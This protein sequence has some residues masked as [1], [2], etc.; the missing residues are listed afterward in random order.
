M[1]S[2]AVKR[3]REVGKFAVVIKHVNIKVMEV[4]GRLSKGSQRRARKLCHECK[5]TFF[6]AARLA[7]W[8][9]YSLG[10]TFQVKLCLFVWC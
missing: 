1:S 2:A 8:C 5:I 7:L 3:E 6:M 9:P 4:V 10:C